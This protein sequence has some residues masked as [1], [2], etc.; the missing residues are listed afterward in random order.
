MVRKNILLTVGQFT[1]RELQLKMIFEGGAGR[2]G[3]GLAKEETVLVYQRKKQLNHMTTI[4][5]LS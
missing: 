4:P 5:Y 2:L 3:G 1:W